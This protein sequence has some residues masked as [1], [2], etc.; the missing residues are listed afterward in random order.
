MRKKFL[1]LMLALTMAVS[2]TACGKEKDVPSSQ[3]GVETTTEEKIEIVYE[4]EYIKLAN[5]KGLECNSNPVEVVEADITGNIESVVNQYY[6]TINNN[7]TTTDATTT[8]AIYY[9]Y[10]NITDDMIKEATSDEYKTVSDYYDH[11]KEELTAQKES[12]HNTT[13]N[14]I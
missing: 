1:C 3:T 10:K 13:I 14:T 5:Y 11:V 7:A 6:A 12:E 4:N 2:V 8:D 9:D